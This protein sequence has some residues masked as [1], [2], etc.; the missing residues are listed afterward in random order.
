MIKTK[1]E[2]EPVIR[3][4]NAR[5][6]EQYS[7]FSGITFFGSRH[8]GDFRV[9]SDFDI[10]V[11]FATK[12]LW[13]KENDVLDMIYET[14]LKYDFVIDAKVYHENEIKECNTPFRETVLTEGTFYAA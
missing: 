5:L 1:A 8:R 11:L 13:K 2:F 10:V 4:L 9:D 3:E 6:K 7:D 14:E 12:P